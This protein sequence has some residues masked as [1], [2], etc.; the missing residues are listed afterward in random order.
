MLAKLATVIKKK[1]SGSKAATSERPPVDDDEEVEAKKARLD[2][3][4]AQTPRKS[5]S[6]GSQASGS[7]QSAQLPNGKA[8]QAERFRYGNYNQ[9]YGA[10]LEQ[11]FQ[12]DPR[13]ELFRKE[14]FYKRAVLDVGCNIGLVTIT[15]AKE[16][17]PR[18][19]VGIDI[20]PA[21]VGIARKNIRHYCGEG[22]ELA[23]GKIPKPKATDGETFPK[24]P[25]N[26]WFVC[27]NYV[28]E[29][30]DLLD[31]VKPEYDAILA[32]SISKW[33]HLNWGDTGLKR[34]FRRAFANLRTGGVFLLEPQEF[35]TYRK[36]AAKC[37]DMK[38]NYEEIQLKPDDFADFLV[39][40]VGFSR[41]EEL[42]RPKAKTKVA[43][44]VNSGFQRP[45]IAFFK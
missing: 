38:K 36:R 22:V 2:E 1:S 33:I 4:P 27:G 43:P 3:P 31:A 37:P 15:L 12:P 20:D 13:F 34:F 21:L 24:F 19:C 40:D 45:L 39:K 6:A 35:S 42:G 26:V 17:E 10:R 9:Y 18:R 7:G 30:D 8:K 25:N 32:L 41:Y 16:F 5:P 29:T 11:K 44:L 28:L 14:W 23:G